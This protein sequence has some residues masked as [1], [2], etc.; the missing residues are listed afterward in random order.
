MPMPSILSGKFVSSFYA[1][2]VSTK[3]RVPPTWIATCRRVGGSRKLQKVHDNEHCDR[4]PY[5]GPADRREAARAS[6]SDGALVHYRRT[7]TRAAGGCAGRIQLV[8][9][10]ED[11]GVLRQQQAAADGGHGGRGQ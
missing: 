10:Y 5:L 9:R 4:S 7:A 3:P 1:E 11:R 2:L 8:P 6:G